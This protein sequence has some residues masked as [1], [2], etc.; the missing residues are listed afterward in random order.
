MPAGERPT[1]MPTAA[2]HQNVERHGRPPTRNSQKQ[3]GRVQEL[4][5]VSATTVHEVI[6]KTDQAVTVTQRQSM[7]LV[8]TFLYSSVSSILSLRDLLPPEHFQT[9]YYATINKH[10]SY[11]DFTSGAQVHYP[12]AGTRRPA[13]NKMSVLKRN[14]S[15]QG[16]RIIDWLV[17][18]PF[19]LAIMY[20]FFKGEG[21][22]RRCQERL[23]R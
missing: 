14:T 2:K 6:A 12:Q 20:S 23:S 18:I 21:G 5:P 9:M 17:S 4:V 11:S 10:C 1:K 16:D 3:A 7:E 15:A 19:V 13:G 8:Q 22:V